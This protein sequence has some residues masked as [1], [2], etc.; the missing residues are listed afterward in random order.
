MASFLR[1]VHAIPRR[2]Q[3]HYTCH[4][5]CECAGIVCTNLGINLPSNTGPLSHTEVTFE[6]QRITI[7]TRDIRHFATYYTFEP[8]SFDNRRSGL[9]RLRKLYYNLL[10]PFY[11]PQ[12]P[13]E[14]DPRLDEFIRLCTELFQLSGLAVLRVEMSREAIT[15]ASSSS[16]KSVR[17]VP[18]SQMESLLRH[19][20][21]IPAIS[22]VLA[23]RAGR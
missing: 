8:S 1:E 12:K 18:K 23:T 13:V 17:F 5:E 16:V 7:T 10:D 14:G 2:F 11:F 4:L 6:G 21:A 3:D 19:V 15:V 22:S 9:S 20:A